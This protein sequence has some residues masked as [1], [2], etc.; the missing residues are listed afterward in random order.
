MKNNWFL[1]L[2]SKLPEQIRTPTTRLRGGVT[3]TFPA[4]LRDR[5]ITGI[6]RRPKL[7]GILLLIAAGS[8]VYLRLSA[9]S[10]QEATVLIPDVPARK[11][12]ARNLR[13]TLDLPG[14]VTY[15]QKAA[16]HSKVPG[17]VARVLVEPGAT[18]RAGQPLAQMETFDLQIRLRQAEAGVRSAAAGVAL[19]RA[20]VQ[21]ARRGIEK[22]LK[23]MQKLQAE[24]LNSRAAFLNSRRV[25]RNKKELY[26]L[27]GASQMELRTAHSEYIAAMSRYYQTR[28]DYEA[29]TIGFRTA[30]LRLAG[31]EVPEKPEVRRQA[32][33]DLNTRVEN[34]E[35]RAADAGLRNAQLERE[36]VQMLL[37]ESVV[38]SPI[39]GRIASR[40]IEA[41]EQ[42][43]PDEPLFTVVRL[44]RL[45]VTSAVSE[46]DLRFVRPDAP[47]EL[48]VEALGNRVLP[49]SLQMISPVVDS[50]TRTAEI[51]TYV[52]NREGHLAPG[53]YARLRLRL[54][55]KAAGIAVPEAA[56]LERKENPQGSQSAFVFVVKESLAMKRKVVLGQTY[57]DEV[58]IVSGLTVGEIIA[59]ENLQL[60]R[61]G[62]RVR[63][64]LPE[65]APARSEKKP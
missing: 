53:M 5:L 16:I 28:K 54:R 49:A 60:L 2:K 8:L 15:Y 17:R 65:E 6:R 18:V 10:P 57:G 43:K 14:T 12:A 35:L 13:H 40:S 39:A 62:A 45:V 33:I 44:D 24:I 31:G 58:E 50:R 25:L 59:L 64:I 61:D 29:G 51:R 37:R 30:D 26:E 3:P 22:E 46:R 4:G 36:T 34:E 42:P 48:F 63:A 19:R 47:V 56:L 7:A 9:P 32:Y 52:E 20:R 38:R 23:G 21:H 11:V 27:G 41:G 1:Q 55:E